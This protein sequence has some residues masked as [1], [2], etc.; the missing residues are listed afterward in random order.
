MN[1]NRSRSKSVLVGLIGWTVGV[2]IGVAAREISATKKR[3]FGRA[4]RLLPEAGVLPR[5]V[6]GNLGGDQ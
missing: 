1:A 3:N 4:E 2:A 6:Q 5:N